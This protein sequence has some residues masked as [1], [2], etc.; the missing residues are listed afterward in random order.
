MKK[1]EWKI[2]NS[3]A[4]V[5]ET[6]SK[7]DSVSCT[8]KRGGREAACNDAGGVFGRTFITASTATRAGDNGKRRMRRKFLSVLISGRA[9]SNT[10]PKHIITRIHAYDAF[11]V[12]YL[13]MG[14]NF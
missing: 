6:E 3:L 5:W 13:K 7:Y 1:Y 8:G 2:R 4:S 12:Q 14:I 10:H 11:I 9:L